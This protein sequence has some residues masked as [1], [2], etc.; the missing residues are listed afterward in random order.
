MKKLL[1]LFLI[2]IFLVQTI[3]AQT[4]LNIYIDSSGNAEFLGE[5]NAT[6]LFLPNGISIQDGKIRGTT[7]ALT[8]KTGELW[9]FSYSLPGAEIKAILPEGAAI[10]SIDNQK[11]E[12]F[13][14][15][16]RISVYF[17]DDLSVSYIVNNTEN[18]SLIIWVIILL[19]IGAIAYFYRSELISI[20][21]PK[22]IYKRTRQKAKPHEEKLEIIKQILND[23]EKI[24]LDK[25]KSA[26]K[27]KMSHLRKLVEIPK[28]S[29]SR[30]VQELEKKGL[31]KKMGEGKNKFV[32][33]VKKI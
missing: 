10:Q 1:P 5:T 33:L 7:G 24:I 9:T 29:F 15:R 22:V 21:K 14:E 32:D 13:I 20:L 28:A 23:R 27:I 8:T 17:Q 19:I 6:S 26:G 31:L 3:S 2:L 11:A 16:G 30:H 4:F 18:P 25:L 12:I